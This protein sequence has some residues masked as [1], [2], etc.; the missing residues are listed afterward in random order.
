MGA[1]MASKEYKMNEPKK[2]DAPRST[3]TRRESGGPS[4]PSARSDAVLDELA[5][6]IFARIETN[7][8]NSNRIDHRKKP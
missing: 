6:R 2:P 4:S 3:E 5:R 1:N 7:P 8:S